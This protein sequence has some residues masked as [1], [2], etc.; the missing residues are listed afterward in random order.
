MALRTIK[1]N[2]RY[3]DSKGWVGG[4]NFFVAGDA[5]SNAPADFA[6]AA[7]TLLTA[8]TALT[9][10]ALQSTSGIDFENQLAITL[11]YG[12]AAQYDAEWMK[13]VMTFT[14]DGGSIHRFK[15]PAPK[16]ALFLADKV[17]IDNGGSNTPVVNF[18]NAMKNADTSGTYIS[19][20]E[21][22]PFT[23]FVGGILRLGK[24]PRR[25]NEFIK[26]A[27]L[28]QGEGE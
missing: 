26:S 17:T 5:E 3:R 6:A 8:V 4:T 18:V 9:N 21:G 27:S 14:C 7:D 23:H 20:R 24:Q 19:T 11:T 16:V 28:V 10:G 1:F 13:A 2:V 12:T 15:I 25:L 22:L